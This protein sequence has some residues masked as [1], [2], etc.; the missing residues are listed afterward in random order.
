MFKE[1]APLKKKIVTYGAPLILQDD[2]KK[3]EQISKDVVHVVHEYDVVPRLLGQKKFN[4]WTKELSD[5]NHFGMYFW[6]KKGKLK[7]IPDKNIPSSGLLSHDLAKVFTTFSDHAML[8]YCKKV[9]NCHEEAEKEREGNVTL[10]IENKSVKDDNKERNNDLKELLDNN[11]I[12]IEEYDEKKKLLEK[13]EK[14]LL[15]EE[16]FEL[17]KKNENKEEKIEIKEEKLD[18]KN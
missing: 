1:I 12:S 16:H 18:I 2:P 14:D 3:I 6:L 15:I 17:E 4:Y 11:Q 13:V 7:Y 9:E 10:N 5:Y 8:L